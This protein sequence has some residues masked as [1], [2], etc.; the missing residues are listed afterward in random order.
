M[1]NLIAIIGTVRRE[2][3]DLSVSEQEKLVRN[4]PNDIYSFLR[5]RNPEAYYNLV[6]IASEQKWLHL[7]RRQ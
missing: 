1:N 2:T 4:M 7:S 6:W 3:N 5:K